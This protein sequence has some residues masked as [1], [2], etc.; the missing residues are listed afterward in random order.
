VETND[1]TSQDRHRGII[2]LS[3]SAQTAS[4]SRFT[5]GAIGGV[6]AVEKAGGLAGAELGLP[7]TRTFDVFAE[8]V[9]M[10]DVATRRRLG[11][12][13][14]VTAFLQ[15]SQGKSATGTIKAPAVYGGAGVRVMFMKGAAI[16][17]YVAVGA[18]AATVTLKPKFTVAGNDVTGSLASYGVALGK[19]IS[20]DTTKAAF[21]G[22]AGVRYPRGRWYIDGDVRVINIRMDDEPINTLRGSA[23]FGF[24]F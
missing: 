21:T 16:Q 9:W 2:P 18:G 11:M 14:T 19:D 7:L 15:S 10:E 5:I 8:G 3:A 17:P 23:T 1:S 6:A 24:R 20:G 12:A 22:G 13:D 4:R